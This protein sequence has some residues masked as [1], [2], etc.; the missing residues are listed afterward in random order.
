[1]LVTLLVLLAACAPAPP[2]SRPGGELRIGRSG[3]VATLDPWAADPGSLRLT[4]QI[5]EPLVEHGPDGA[6]VG[7]L[8]TAWEP[9]ADGRVWRLTVRDGVRF[10]DGTP[11]DAAAVAFNFDRARLAAH[12]GRAAPVAGPSAYARIWGLGEGSLIARVD[13]PEPRTVVFTLRE[14]FG[15]FLAGL[16]VPSFAMVSPAAIAADPQGWMSPGTGR[17]A[18]TGPFQLAPG[19]RRPNGEI[20]LERNE[21]YWERDPRGRALPYLDQLVFRA[22]AAPVEQAAA[23]RMGALDVVPEVGPADLAALRGHPNLKVLSRPAQSLVFLGIAHSSGPLAD[24]HVRRA[25]AQA[26]NR[27]PLVRAAYGGEGAVASQ[28]V[29]PGIVGYDDSI[30]EFTRYDEA[31][32]RR[33]LIQAGLPQGFETELWYV[34]DES[35][36]SSAARRTAEAFRADLARIGVRVTLR[37]ADPA[38]VDREA[39]AGRLP[40]WIGSVTPEVADA[41]P[42]FGA[43]L[44]STRGTG[45]DSGAWISP[46]VS[47]LLDRARTEHRPAVRAE[48]Y[49]QVSKIVQQEIGAVPVLYTG[50]AIGLAR[51][52]EGMEPHRSGYETLHRTSLGR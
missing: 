45:R 37:S 17:A 44:G 7:R 24:L 18:G 32:A 22:P 5:F 8:V 25:V 11:F 13:A 39:R 21:R 12:S 28:I 10:H 43:V 40:L 33:A 48:L 15:P 41:D 38:T 3:E 26:L 20:V 27:E 49:K 30:T 51:R 42:L 2:A 16:A 1:M 23:L 46:R 36:P 31:A 35:S 19:V 50:A 9:S 52:V 14:P 4:S 34:A 47:A 6:L 29:L